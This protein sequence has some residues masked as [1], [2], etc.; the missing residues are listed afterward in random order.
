MNCEKIQELMWQS[1]ERIQ[2]SST[3]AKHLLICPSCRKTCREYEVLIGSLAEMPLMEPPPGFTMRI[4]ARVQEQRV[5]RWLMRWAFA[6]V[7]AAA[8]AGWWI[9]PP[10]IDWLA[11]ATTLFGRGLTEGWREIGPQMTE[12]RFL[13]LP[14]AHLIAAAVL[15]GLTWVA[16]EI[17]G[18]TPQQKTLK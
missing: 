10:L 13:G 8:A 2:S 3:V 16:A 7:I 12:G 14:L 18:T 17:W 9:G 4:V 5:F 1:E 15:W 6:A 11:G